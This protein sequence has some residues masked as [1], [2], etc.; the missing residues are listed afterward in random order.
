MAAG[1]TGWPVTGLTPID[2]DGDVWAPGAAPVVAVGDA[3]RCTRVAAL[4]ELPDA[5]PPHAATEMTVA[6]AAIP[7]VSFR[8]AIPPHCDVSRTAA[9]A[10][11][12]TAAR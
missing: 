10:M 9:T 5:P 12:T 1:G 6:A 4:D 11:L 8:K 2:G 3:V 7:I